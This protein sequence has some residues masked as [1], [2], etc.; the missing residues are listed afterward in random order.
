M[1]IALKEYRRLSSLRRPQ[2]A[3]ICYA[4]LGRLGV[5]ASFTLPSRLAHAQTGHSTLL[6]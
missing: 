2:I 1:K 3:K 4:Q 5:V 6:Y